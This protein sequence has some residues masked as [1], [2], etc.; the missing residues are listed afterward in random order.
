MLA[1][2]MRRGTL[3]AL[4]GVAGIWLCTYPLLRA[5]VLNFFSQHASVALGSLVSGAMLF[6]P[7]LLMLGS[8]SPVLIQYI[9]ARHPGAGSAAGR[10]FFT[11]TI[12]GLVGGWGTAFVLIPYAS[13]RQFLVATGA[14]LILLALLWSASAPK[15]SG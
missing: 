7:P 4:F 3:A 8:V 5:P 11:N 2:S 13:L 15:A 1:K 12:G 9:D 10:L 14:A 6:G